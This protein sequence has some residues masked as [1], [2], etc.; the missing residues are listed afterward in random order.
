MTKCPDLAAAFAVAENNVR[1]EGLD[2]R[3]Q[4]HYESIKS[5]V[6]AGALILAQAKAEVLRHH[7]VQH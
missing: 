7:T 2:P 6:I 3:G 4:P 1:L 5:A